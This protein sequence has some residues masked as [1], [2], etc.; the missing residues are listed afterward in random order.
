MTRTMDM[1]V[2]HLPIQVKGSDAPI[3]WGQL[4]MMVIEG[5]LFAILIASYC[6]VRVNFAVW[7]PPGIENPGLVLP[8]IGFVVLMI[9]CVPMVWSEKALNEHNRK[10]VLL[11]LVIN[12]V[13][14]VAFLFIRW[15]EFVAFDFKW[16][17]NIYGSFVW[18]MLGLHT[19]H[20]IA[21]TLETIV[22][23]VIVLTRKVGPKQQEGLEV[24]GFYWGFVVVSWIPLFFIIYLYPYLVKPL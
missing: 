11:G 5:V 14:A 20:T 4:L 8:T 10:K 3:W 21:D 16:N 12:A 9:S 18:S 13:M 6:Y 17:T 15:R 23:I 24:D 1:D 7:P 19:M 2:A 22:F